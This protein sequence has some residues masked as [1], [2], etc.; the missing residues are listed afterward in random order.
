MNR[1]I[2]YTLLFVSP[3]LISIIGIEVLL[4]NQPNIYKEK[5]KYLDQE[6]QNIQVIILGSSHGIT[7][8][9]PDAFSKNAYNTANYAQTLDYD[10]AIL[11]KYQDKLS[12]LE[13]IIVPLSYHI[14]W[15]RLEYHPQIWR[16]K[17]YSIYYGITKDHNPFKNLLFMDEPI[18]TDIE[19]I[20]NYYY[21]KDNNIEED[22]T[23][24]GL[25]N[26]L[27][28]ADIEVLETKSHKIIGAH[29]A[30]DLAF[31][32]DQNMQD[33]KGII[34][35]AKKK[36]AKVIFVTLPVYKTFREL[37]HP[38]QLE[39]LYKTGNQLQDGKSVFYFNMLDVL[40]PEL[41]DGKNEVFFDSDHL[42]SKG[43]EIVGHKL[44]SIIRTIEKKE[45]SANLPN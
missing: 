5:A 33:L 29:H 14:L 30:P 9:D 31:M 15:T 4:R 22:L 20:W 23:S 21:N 7:G 19:T 10:Y 16:S 34:E 44:D 1:F 45:K 18:G 39:L 27:P 3:F 42:S 41:K 13:Y 25:N 24:K 43:A 32:Y 38:K 8:I 35:I 26:L 12:S 11:D 28:E 2:L 17:Y 36:N 37:M 40:D 6:A